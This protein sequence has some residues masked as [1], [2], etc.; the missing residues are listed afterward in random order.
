MGKKLS[1]INKLEIMQ[2]YNKKDNILGKTW[3]IFFYAY[4]WTLHELAYFSPLPSL[5]VLLH[6]LR[7]VK[8]GKNVYIGPKCHLDY[9]YPK[10][11]EIEDNVSIGMDSYIFTHANP[12]TCQWIKENIHPRKVA[13]VTIK[14]GSWIG[15]RSTILCGVT[16]GKRSIIGSTSLIT[17]SLEDYSLCAPKPTEFIRKI[18][19]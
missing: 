19:R 8:I 5:S 13:P 6:K 4:S 10:L 9:L 15:A 11:I 17:K 18:K 1:E 16:I 3:L 2:F 7:G 12:G 14:E